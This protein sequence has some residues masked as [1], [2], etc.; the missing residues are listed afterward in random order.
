MQLSNRQVWQLVHA[1]RRRLIE[2]LQALEERQWSTASLCPGW[3]VHDVVAHLV[4]TARTGRVG[5]V[6]SMIR[7]RG[8][9]NEANERGVGRYRAANPGQ[10][11][12]LF[13]QSMGLQLTPPAHRATRLVEAIVHGE[14]IR[15]PLGIEGDYPRHAVTEAINYQLRTPVAFGGGRERARGLCLLD[16]ESQHS[17]GHGRQVRGSGIDLL[18]ALSGRPVERGLLRGSGVGQLTQRSE[19]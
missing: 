14:D 10:T 16:A 19:R 2:D 15:R 9:F 5:F 7:S 8:N 11:L 1:E 3:S 18:M 4:D 13:R 6:A 12:E 17:W